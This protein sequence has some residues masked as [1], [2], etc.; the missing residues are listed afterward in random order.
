MTQ[1]FVI[2]FDATESEDRFR[3]SVVESPAGQTSGVM[4]LPFTFETLVP[5]LNQFGVPVEEPSYSDL[6]GKKDQ[7]KMWTPYDLGVGLYNTLIGSRNL[8]G[9]FNR[10]RGR[11]EDDLRLYLQFNPTDPAQ[12]SLMRIPWETMV[13]E[14]DVVPLSRT[15]GLT[16]ARLIN[17]KMDET[18]PVLPSESLRML[19]I[20]ASPI[21]QHN[22][23]PG[24]YR[25]SIEVSMKPL[26]LDIQFLENATRKNLREVLKSG[27]FQLIYFV[28]HGGYLEDEGEWCFALED[29]D[30]STDSL[31]VEEI[32]QFLH[33]YRKDVRL[34]TMLSCNSGEIDRWNGF[35]PFGGLAGSLLHCGIENVIAMQYPISFE[36][37]TQF[38]E[39]FFPELLR[40]RRID[41]A[42]TKARTNMFLM[43]KKSLEWATPVWFTRS[44]QV[45]LYQIAKNPLLHVNTYLTHLDEEDLR[46][47]NPGL[48]LK[49]MDFAHQFADR[50]IKHPSFWKDSI[51][52]EIR[53]FQSKFA[54]KRV[55]LDITGKENLS[56]WL[57]LGF[58]FSKT[59]SAD[60]NF[61]Q[62]NTKDGSDEIW[63]TKDS[64]IPQSF[65]SEMMV[66]DPEGKDLMVSISVNRDVEK[67]AE[68]YMKEQKLSI[69]SW[70]KLSFGKDGGHLK[71]GG[72]A[73]GLAQAMGKRIRRENDTRN[74]LRVHLFVASPSGFALFLGRELNAL[75]AVQVYEHVPPTYEPSFVLKK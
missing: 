65:E 1:N 16:L 74:P 69:H 70:L 31:T 10:A 22:F 43:K 60:L 41:L 50:S 13:A 28:G 18:V 8:E 27:P 3:F 44:R 53:D 72:E 62:R 45:E 40:T 11:T 7:E 57:A 30:G 5:T 67:T 2:Q 42:L 63:R 75:N 36:G 47:E 26:G 25:Q 15:K 66:M 37:A 20:L 55:E 21:D 54:G 68:Q 14:G 35:N 59:S 34:I 49:V 19:V 39:S 4:S 32:A 64:A 48:E 29:E 56:I 73:L 61:L 9:C 6:K 58:V 52:K 33:E 46:K 38:N 23:Q 71:G 51:L 17:P 12:A 24:K